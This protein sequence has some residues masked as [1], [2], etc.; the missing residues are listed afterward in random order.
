LPASRV[1]AREACAHGRA[2]RMWSS[3]FR[4]RPRTSLLPRAVLMTSV[5]PARDREATARTAAVS[6]EPISGQRPDGLTRLEDL[7]VRCRRTLRPLLSVVGHL[8]AL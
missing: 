3:S 4:L 7:Y 6:S 2:S 1:A 5:R 8:C